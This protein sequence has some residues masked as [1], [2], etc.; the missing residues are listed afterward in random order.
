MYGGWWIWDD[1]AKLG[2]V[3]KIAAV[4]LLKRLKE[5]GEFPELADIED[6]TE[7]TDDQITENFIQRL[8]SRAHRGNF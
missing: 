8:I 2:D 3:D 7:L 5:E 1:Q 6:W 4:E